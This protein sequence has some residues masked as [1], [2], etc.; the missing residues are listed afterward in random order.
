MR[1]QRPEL[2][3]SPVSVLLPCL[4]RPGPSH[5][6][7][8]DCAGASRSLEPPCAKAAAVAACGAG[9]WQGG[10]EPSEPSGSVLAVQPGEP[11]SP[12]TGMFILSELSAHP[13]KL[14]ILT[15][16]VALASLLLIN[17][18]LGACPFIYFQMVLNIFQTTLVMMPRERGACHAWQTKHRPVS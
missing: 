1:T 8:L 13:F 16:V 5:V 17:G 12:N 11:I 10:D 15:F 6:P 14:G 18:F 2:A 7:Q 9:T 3:G 4:A